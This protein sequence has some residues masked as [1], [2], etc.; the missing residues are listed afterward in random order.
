MPVWKGMLQTTQ[1][2]V[3][4]DSVAAQELQER[5]LNDFQTAMLT[6]TKNHTVLFQMMKEALIQMEKHTNPQNQS[7]P[8]RGYV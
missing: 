8:I 1:G 2:A 4:S 6:E 7:Q 3:D 5:V